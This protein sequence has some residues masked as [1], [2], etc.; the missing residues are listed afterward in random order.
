MLVR[1][2]SE[3]MST[4]NED[5]LGFLDPHSRESS[6]DSNL[7]DSSSKKPRHDKESK[8]ISHVAKQ[9]TSRLYKS[10]E[11]KFK[12]VPK[13]KEKEV[14]TIP[15][16]KIHRDRGDPM[17]REL[18]DN[19][20]PVKVLRDIERSKS[21][22]PQR[23]SKRSNVSPVK[24]LDSRKRAT[25]A[26]NKPIPDKSKKGPVSK[27]SDLGDRKT[28]DKKRPDTHSK[29]GTK[30]GDKPKGPDTQDDQ[31]LGGVSASVR[32]KG[33]NSPDRT[34]PL[35]P[36]RLGNGRHMTSA[37]SLASVPESIAEQDEPIS[38]RKPE[39]ADTIYV[40]K[41]RAKKGRA[42]FLDDGFR[43]HSAPD[44]NSM[45]E[46]FDE[47]KEQ[48][49]TEETP[50]NETP[51]FQTSVSVDE[52]DLSRAK[53]QPDQDNETSH[54]PAA[55]I[56]GVQSI[57]THSPDGTSKEHQIDMSKDKNSPTDTVEMVIKSQEVIVVENETN[58]PSISD[59]S[60]DHDKIPKEKTKSDNETMSRSYPEGVKELSPKKRRKS[61]DEIFSDDSLDSDISVDSLDEKSSK[62]LTQSLPP[63]FFTSDKHMASDSLSNSD[64]E[65]TDTN[66]A[67]K[68]NPNTSENKQKLSRSKIIQ[69]DIETEVNKTS[70][71]RNLA[72]VSL[73]QINI[74]SLSNEVDPSL[75]ENDGDI[76]DAGAFVVEFNTLENATAIKVTDPFHNK[77]INN[78]Q[79]RKLSVTVHHCIDI[80][81]DLLEVANKSEEIGQTCEGKDKLQIDEVT[82]YVS[83]IVKN[84]QDIL[85]KEDEDIEI[86][87]GRSELEN[88]EESLSCVQETNQTVREPI[89][90]ESESNTQ[91][92][93]DVKITTDANTQSRCS[94]DTPKSVEKY[95]SGIID[96]AKEQMNSTGKTACYEDQIEQ[97]NEMVI[98]SSI[99]IKSPE[100]ENGNESEDNV[101]PYNDKNEPAVHVDGETSSKTDLD[102]GDDLGDIAV[103]D[104]S[105]TCSIS[106][107]KGN[108]DHNPGFSAQ[109]SDNNEPTCD[110]V[111]CEKES[112]EN[113]QGIPTSQAEGNSQGQSREDRE[114]M[115]TDKASVADEN[116]NVLS[117]NFND[118]EMP[119]LEGLGESFDLNLE[120][121]ALNVVVG[122]LA[123][124]MATDTLRGDNISF[125]E[126]EQ[127]LNGMVPGQV[128]SC[129]LNVVADILAKEMLEDG[130]PAESNDNL[131]EKNEKDNLVMNTVDAKE[132]SNNDT[133]FTEHHLAEGAK[134]NSFEKDLLKQSEL[135]LVSRNISSEMLSDA[136]QSDQTGDI[137]L[138]SSNAVPDDQSKQNG[139][140]ISKQHTRDKDA[141]DFDEH[142]E[143]AADI[144]EHVENT[145]QER[146]LIENSSY[147]SMEADALIKSDDI[148]AETSENQE[149]NHK[150]DVNIEQKVNSL[151][152]THDVGVG[153]ST[154]LLYDMDDNKRASD[155]SYM[156]TQE[157]LEKLQEALEQ[158]PK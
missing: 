150:D 84:T 80:E 110:K 51:E 113:V 36:G 78:A 4:S 103:P 151:V 37:S 5:G 28:I 138:Q 63:S 72:T 118:L 86:E 11:P 146:D 81:G 35:G 71:T 104:D 77:T 129:N 117:V 133:I 143:N 38:P 8:N 14:K 46:A 83:E 101:K 19:K 24:E 41:K 154:E 32:K 13:T 70:E 130:I 109:T 136:L 128:E 45:A 132:Q 144:Y 15:R 134:G 82:S 93:H 122:N 30:K 66:I 107:A 123:H 53:E 69:H 153:T 73:E 94:D 48:I 142:V 33:T 56:T 141:I 61:N 60:I 58:M 3:R 34:S 97:E 114:S 137:K 149:K 88:G 10:S 126:T 85:N 96:H 111:I 31:E 22:S 55:G 2:S 54:T 127:V 147:E 76:K 139:S 12:Y 43:C 158:L 39:S 29:T 115:P 121:V 148:T 125:D 40:V 75:S 74:S 156:D 52:S 18:R 155:D 1:S 17:L 106:G 25:S 42:S 67:L 9:V 62:R 105:E 20:S 26:P 49:E 47:Y 124:D 6:V 44:S 87:N 91:E 102:L 145:N 112:T 64:D 108:V 23:H 157:E 98:E 57:E 95:I 92:V 140:D 65:D 50:E 89:P 21:E 120:N 7:G 79:I 131:V 119:E 116:D 99:S 27:G 90:S 59:E 152:R 16:T 135:D 100:V 68:V